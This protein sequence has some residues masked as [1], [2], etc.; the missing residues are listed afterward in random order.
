MDTFTSKEAITLAIASVGAVLGIIN[1]WKTLDKDRPKLRVVPKQAFAVGE[2]AHYEP[3]TRLCIEVTNLS[4][5]ALTVSEVGVLYHGSKAR[6]ALIP[7]IVIDGGTFP[8]RLEPRSS[9]TTYAAPN[10]LVGSPHPIKCAYAATDCGL[11][12]EGK[13]GALKQLEQEANR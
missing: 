6:G 3:D 5:F 1:T 7:P 9:F 13:S 10:A 4:T 12:F 8:R 2:L 11:M